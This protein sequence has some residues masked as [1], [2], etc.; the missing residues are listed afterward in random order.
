MLHKQIPGVLEFLDPTPGDNTTWRLRDHSLQPR[1]L[2]CSVEGLA[3]LRR[4]AKPWRHPRL[5]DPWKQGLGQYD[6]VWSGSFKSV[7]DIYEKVVLENHPWGLSNV[8]GCPQRPHQNFFMLCSELA[9]SSCMSP[10][11][12]GGT[13]LRRY[14]PKKDA[15]CV[16]RGYYTCIQTPRMSCR[17]HWTNSHGG[18][19]SYRNICKRQATWDPAFFEPNHQYQ[20]AFAIM[21]Q[22]PESKGDW[23]ILK[24]RKR[25]KPT[26]QKYG[27]ATDPH[28]KTKITGY[29]WVQE[30][31]T[32]FSIFF[33]I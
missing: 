24:V 20:E 1:S 6:I 22:V 29:I 33:F 16:R 11:D 3:D 17:L 7:Y 23:K 10:R 31:H 30:V 25:G 32:F 12:C 27:N 8:S 5:V 14:H 13:C 26:K 19:W 18:P 15:T 2:V 28:T 21:P 4:V 9:T